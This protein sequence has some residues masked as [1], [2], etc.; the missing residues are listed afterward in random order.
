MVDYFLPKSLN[1]LYFW[2]YDFVQISLACGLNTYQI[3]YGETFKYNNNND[4]GSLKRLPMSATA[5][6]T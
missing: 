6:V 1:F 4:I 5:M 2:P 3:M